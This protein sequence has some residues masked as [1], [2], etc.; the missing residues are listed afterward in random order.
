VRY[1]QIKLQPAVTVDGTS[2][3]SSNGSPT[4]SLS[5]LSLTVVIPNENG[6]LNDQ[7][8]SQKTP[9]PPQLVS[10]YM[11]DS[12]LPVLQLPTSQ[13]SPPLSPVEKEVTTTLG[14]ST[15]NLRSRSS[16][17]RTP[18]TP[19]KQSTSTSK[20]KQSANKTIQSKL[21]KTAKEQ[22]DPPIS[23]SNKKLLPPVSINQ[24]FPFFFKLLNLPYS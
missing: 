2:N 20:P 19:P 14:R 15:H 17:P 18:E 13:T 16:F 23:K 7:I 8:S 12:P 21:P 10:L 5:P 24:R 11:N 4:P 6:Y 22:V 1:Q 9:S 3:L